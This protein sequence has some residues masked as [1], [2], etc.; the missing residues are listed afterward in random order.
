MIINFYISGLIA[1]I[2]MIKEATGQFVVDK[3]V[4]LIQSTI[5]L[6]VSIILAKFIGL[7]GV[8]LGTTISYVTV[9]LWNRPYIAYKYIFKSSKK[10]FI[11]QQIK[12]V[13]T[14]ILTILLVH[15]ILRFITIDNNI[16]MFVITGV[17]C[18]IV[19]AILTILI[20][21]NTDEYDYIKNETLKIIRR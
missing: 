1:S 14:M 21:R 13:L 10:H 17:I 3:F 8:V 19:F 7:F 18:V 6:I 9:S 5:N 20:F 15:G 4:P 12:Y 16:I 11:T 2:D